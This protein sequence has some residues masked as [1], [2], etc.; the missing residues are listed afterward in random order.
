MAKKHTTPDVI[1]DVEDTTPNVSRETFGQTPTLPPQ[2]PYKVG[3]VYMG[4][5]VAYVNAVGNVRPAVVIHDLLGGRV[6]LQ[7]FN[8][9]PEDGHS[10]SDGLTW[11]ESVE[12]DYEMWPN[13]WHYLTKE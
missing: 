10:V 8:D 13:T 12:Y 5:M 1:N 2:D 3:I 9:G 4:M 6:T 7:A 11:V